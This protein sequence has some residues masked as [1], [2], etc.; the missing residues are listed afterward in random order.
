ML[1]GLLH[2]A[3]R[4]APERTAIVYGTARISYRRLLRGVE[5]FAAE[6]GAAGLEASD[7]VSLVLGNNPQ[8]VVALF[9]AARRGCVVLPLSPQLADDAL[10]RYFS[11]A[12]PRRVVTTQAQAERCRQALARSELEAA[13]SVVSDIA[14]PDADVDLDAPSEAARTPF[15][16]RAL[17]L[18]TSGSEGYKKRICRTQENLYYESINF[19]H[20]ATLG[21]E[22]TVGCLV[23]LYHSYGLGNGLLAAVGAGSTLVLLAPRSEEGEQVELPFAARGKEALALLER[24]GVRVLAAV[25]HQYE[26]L[27]QLPR[28]PGQ[29]STLPALRWCLNSG[30]RLPLEVYQ[31][32]LERFGTPI[33]QLYGSTETGSIAANL[34]TDDS[35][36]PDGVGACL[37]NVKVSIVDEQGQEL[38]PGAVG[39]VLVSSPVLPPDGYDGHP[40]ATRAAFSGGFYR[41]GDLGCLSQEGI[42]RIVGRKQTFIDTGGYKVDP[43]NVETVLLD[44]PWVREAVVLGVHAPGLGQ[45]VKAVIVAQEGCDEAS[46][47][48]HCQG[49]LAAYEV[50]RLFDFRKELP[51]SPL[52]KILKEELLGGA[53]AGGG[54]FVLGSDGAF[55]LER[56]NW[57]RGE[58]QAPGPGEV[59][60]Q[61]LAAGLGALDA[62]LGQGES[63]EASSGGTSG[64]LRFGSECCGRVVSL[65]EGVTRLN[66]GDEVIAVTF[67]CL[68]SHV[69]VPE[70]L[71]VP[72]PRSLTVEEAA[73]LPATYVLAHYALVQVAR[74]QKGE[75][76]LIH[77]AGGGIGLAALQTA[78]HRGAEVFATADSE[79]RRE[80]LRASGAARVM[81]S[82]SRALPDEV[83]QHT[84]G[85]GF[86][87]I[88]NSLDGEFLPPSLE[89]LHEG[90]RFVELDKRGAHADHPLGLGPFQRGLG[91]TLVDL[92]GLLS[93][94]P[95]LVSTVLAEV[96]TLAEEGVYRPRIDRSFPASE[97]HEAFRYLE[98]AAYV[99]PI[100]ID[101][102]DSELSVQPSSARIEPELRGA[103]EAELAS[104][105]P[106]EQRAFLEERIRGELAELLRT[107]RAT[108]PRREPLRTL[109]L[110]SLHTVLLQQRLASMCGI[111]L[112]VTFIWE[113]PSIEELAAGL[114][115]E[116]RL[117]SNKGHEQTPRTRVPPRMERT[118]DEPFAIIGIGCRLP[119]GTTSPSAFWELLSNGV[120]AIREVP[121]ERWRADD[122]LARAG[123]APGLVAP[124]WGGFLDDI[125]GFDASFFGITSREAQAMDPQQRL[126]LEVSW[127]ALEDAGL[128]PLGLRES[129][130]GV[131]VGMS[132]SDY[133]ARALYPGDLSRITPYSSTGSIFSVAAGRISYVLGLSGPSL[134]VDTACS[135][136]LQ[137]IHLACQSLRT[138]EC[139][140]ALAGGVNLLLEPHASLAMGRMEALAPDGRCKPFDASADGIVR[141]EGCAVIALKPLSAALRDRDRIYA[142]IRGS[143]SNHDGRSNG[144]TAPNGRA[145]R[146]VIRQALARARVSPAEVGYV[147]THGTG[148]RLGDP[149]EVHAL[150]DVLGEGRDPERPVLL[151]AVKS[152]IG[153][154]EA[155]AGV[156]GLIKASLVFQHGTIPANLHFREPNPHIAWG[157][158]AM[159]VAA[160]PVAWPEREGERRIAGVSAFGLS[161][162]NVHVILEEPPRGY[163]P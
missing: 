147:E 46:L 155:C 121:G 63:P 37:E 158:L 126:L 120:D 106:E 128:P 138:G 48:R 22:D 99:G 141:S 57:K 47:V 110:D 131:F 161:G 19:V 54:C 76:L 127:E 112:T 139:D 65:G 29:P 83:R 116:L 98:T 1:Y 20:S 143:A 93:H 33:R 26:A 62:R 53:G 107:D 88:L 32:F 89:L 68:A 24:E 117:S 79:A 90:G 5:G 142:L 75:R 80:R 132:F 39:A 21:P 145:Q 105:S 123:G 17:Y 100:V 34:I 70:A 153:H 56:M 52:G 81:D 148:T 97:I 111:A 66:V 69:C 7:C 133:A 73:A 136:S 159:R 36:R 125:E 42:L 77:A 35:F 60:I 55:G 119:G 74:L 3:A 41:T 2:R 50:P 140:M 6:L 92:H 118:R 85:G 137:A 18:Y 152:N 146:A 49:R 51:R 28:E 160:T 16:G 67:G 38:P 150:G 108:L 95:Q 61:V 9:A 101:L 130:T 113:H 135:S 31:R 149:I 96:A 102:R 154:T 44:H 11:D 64:A 91:F 104:R 82:H 15:R 115:R 13:V 84:H 14:L 162:T 23:P 43:R 12:R 157:P 4:A 8:F 94:R 86:D 30:N 144:L 45:V 109:G 25:A 163:V 58:P 27:A 10:V 124:R 72:K 134:V 114:L 59:R 151:G 156:A 71:V 122:V 129:R 103:L 40:E 87:V 78:Q